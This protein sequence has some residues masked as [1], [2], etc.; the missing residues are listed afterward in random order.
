MLL[1]LQCKY[2]YTFKNNNKTINNSISLN[3]II[4]YSKILLNNCKINF[5]ITKIEKIKLFIDQRRNS[6]KKNCQNLL[7][8]EHLTLFI[9]HKTKKKQQVFKNKFFSIIN[10]L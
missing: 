7:K 4:N 5:L 3:K 2:T 9:T 6:K 1:F 8:M 10:I